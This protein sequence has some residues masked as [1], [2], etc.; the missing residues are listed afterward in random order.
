MNNSSND[1]GNGNDNSNGNRIVDFRARYPPRVFVRRASRPKNINY[2]GGNLHLSRRSRRASGSRSASGRLSGRRNCGPSQRGGITG[3]NLHRPSQPSPLSKVTMAYQDD[4]SFPSQG[5][6]QPQQRH[7]QPE[8]PE[9]PEMPGA[10]PSGPPPK[11]TLAASEEQPTEPMSKKRCVRWETDHAPTQTPEPQD[12]L[13][14]S[15]RRDTG[16]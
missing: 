14:G 12:S 7:G 9:L 3:P 13:S 1:N 6:E 10:A 5:P 11:R 2:K 4:D 15:L 16:T 8:L